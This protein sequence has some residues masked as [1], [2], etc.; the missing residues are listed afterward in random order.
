MDLQ[1]RQ[2]KYLNKDGV[3]GSYLTS[4]R[5]KEP[6]TAEEEAELFERIAQG[7]QDAKNKLI[8]GHQKFVYK[9]A[10]IYAK[11]DEDVLDYV[12]EGTIGLIK[13]I[14]NYNPNLGFRFLT[15][16]SY[17]IRR[18]MNYFLSTNCVVKKS[19]DFK[20][21]K[22]IEKIKRTFYAQNGYEPSEDEIIDRL[23]LDYNIDVIDKSDIYDLNISSISNSLDSESDSDYTTESTPY[24]NE[25]TSS[26]N[27]YEDTVDSEYRK[28]RYLSLLTDALSVLPDD[29]NRDMLCK[30]YGVG[31][32][33]PFSV[34][35]VANEY[36]MTESD[37]TS[38]KN[39]MLQYIR[40]RKGYLKNKVAL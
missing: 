7:D 39:K 13:A 19:N 37:V 17:Y 3:H 35:D 8:E 18:E 11:S 28:E 4:I 10:K 36:N 21:G 32:E 27:L 31:Y 25:K 34:F 9:V 29:R 12:N 33:K 5:H 20:L 2:T 23:S 14:D 1:N 30:L 24:Y 16:A 40:Q 38:L 6:P 26:E 22:K 15:F